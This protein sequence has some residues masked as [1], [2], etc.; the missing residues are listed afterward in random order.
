MP[1]LVLLPKRTEAV[2][3]LPTCKPCA[4]NP[5]CKRLS[6]TLSRVSAS[7]KATDM[8]EEDTAAELGG[9][10][11]IAG[12]QEMKDRVRDICFSSAGLGFRYR[13]K[14]ERCKSTSDLLAAG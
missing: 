1:V 5:V 6:A 12:L 7:V 2:G 8:V 11:C 3:L 9:R 13:V 4:L 10:G 14:Q